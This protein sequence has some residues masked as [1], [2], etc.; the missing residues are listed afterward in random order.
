M[1]VSL[2]HALQGRPLD[3]GG[4]AQ[5]FLFRYVNCMAKFFETVRFRVYFGQILYIFFSSKI[6][7]FLYKKI[8]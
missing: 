6:A 5:E 2:D 1:Q 7:I 8:F 3:L 4:G